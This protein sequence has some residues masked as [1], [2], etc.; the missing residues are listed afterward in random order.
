MR[1]RLIFND[2]QERMTFATDIAKHRVLVFKLQFGSM[3]F[4]FI[5]LETV[6]PRR[7]VLNISECFLLRTARASRHL[8]GMFFLGGV[9]EGPVN[10]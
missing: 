10:M 6:H 2:F 5:G 4:N 3:Y 1:S 8:Q 9:S 7:W